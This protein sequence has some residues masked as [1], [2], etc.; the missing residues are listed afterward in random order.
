MNT[1]TS[2]ESANQRNNPFVVKFQERY[3]DKTYYQQIAQYLEK[4]TVAY[5]LCLELRSLQGINVL[6]L[7][8]D[9]LC[10]YHRIIVSGDTSEEQLH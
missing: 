1:M 2:Q 7:Q 5:P 10:E 8:K 3:A 9:L 6:H 4:S